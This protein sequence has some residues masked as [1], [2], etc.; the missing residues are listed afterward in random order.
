MR[1]G[2]RYYARRYA[3]RR[4]ASRPWIPWKRR[5]G[6]PAYTRRVKDVIEDTKALSF[7]LHA[8]RL[9]RSNFHG[10][11]TL[12]MTLRLRAKMFILPSKRLLLGDTPDLPLMQ[13]KL[14]RIF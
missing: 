5:A 7:A 2:A 12:F 13:M 8:P 4:V 1:V 14:P 11:T 9:R 6:T 3:P 10:D